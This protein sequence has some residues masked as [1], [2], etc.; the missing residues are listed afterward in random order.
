MLTAVTAGPDWVTVAFQA[1]VTCW[2]PGKLQPR[3]QLL[4]VVVPVLVTVTFAVN[5]PA[6]SFFTYDTWHVPVL[7]PPLM[8]QVND[9]EPDTPAV[10]VAV[11]VTVEVPD[12]VGV[13]VI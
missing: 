2:S 5:P 1:F 6:H 8:V 12:V 3:L 11:T 4:T 7:V 9:A 10:S 13:P